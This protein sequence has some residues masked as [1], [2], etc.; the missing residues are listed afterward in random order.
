M[1]NILHQ[2]LERLE[3]RLQA[4]IEGNTARLFPSYSFRNDLGQRLVEA[5]QVEIHPDSE[6]SLTAPNLFTI[7]LP[8]EQAEIFQ[9]QQELL[10]ELADCLCRACQ[11]TQVH[12]I[13]DPVVKVIPISEPST[14]EI[15]I[16]A[17]FSLPPEESTSVLEPP[18]A[19]NPAEQAVRAFLIVDGTQVFPLSGKLVCIGQSEENELV[20]N[21]PQVSPVHAQLR[22][23]NGQYTIFDLNSTSGTFVNGVKVSQYP[24]LP[25]DVISLGGLPLV[26]GIDQRAD[27]DPTQEMSLV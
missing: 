1:A 3:K 9:N 4:L 18:P 27:L 12:F 19:V 13:S 15:Q 7:F 6:G 17:Q 8:E 2:T 23:I 26:F 20:V 25:G 24:L 11:D 22:L 5:M 10:D 21:H 14:A 16:I